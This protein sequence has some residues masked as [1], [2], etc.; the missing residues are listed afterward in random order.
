MNEEVNLPYPRRIVLFISLVTLGTSVLFAANRC[1]DTST[2]RDKEIVYRI[3]YVREHPAEYAF[4]LEDLIEQ[5]HG[6]MRKLPDG[7][8]LETKEGAA[9]VEEAAKALR[10]TKPL[11]PIQWDPCLSESSFAHVLDTGPKGL[12]GH[13]SSNGKDFVTRIRRFQTG[14]RTVG[15]NIS[16]GSKTAEDVV[17]DLIIDDGVPSRGHRK[18]ILAAGFDSA[19]AACGPHKQYGVMCVIDFAQ[20]F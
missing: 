18:N 10:R 20:E 4:H 12:V 11:P 17:R 16:Y 3:N 6:R 9:A 7:V 5:F 2:E 13:N 14:F 19:G 15:E 8:F 1:D